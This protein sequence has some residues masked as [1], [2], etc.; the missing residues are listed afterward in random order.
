MGLVY[1]ITVFELLQ[2]KRNRG[3]VVFY[4]FKD[5]L[6]YCHDIEG[7]FQVMGNSC[8]PS[9]WRLVIDSSFRSLKVV[10][11]HHTNKCLSVPLAHSVHMKEDIRSEHQNPL[12]WIKV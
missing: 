6:C 2:K 10:L 12:E 1:W 4:M 7:L 9:E 5:G 3:F 8:N 11:L